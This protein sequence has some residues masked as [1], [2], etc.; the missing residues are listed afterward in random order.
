[1]LRAI[2]IIVALVISGVLLFAAT[3]PDTFRIQRTASIKAP[4]E[5]LF[6]LI[7][8]LRRFNTWNPYEKKD[9][10]MK[11]RYSGAARGKGAAY[12]FAGNRDVGMGSIEITDSAAPRQVSMRLHMI[13]PFEASNNIEFVLEPKGEVTQ[14]TWAME[15]NVPYPAKILQLFVSMDRMVGQDFEAGL[16]N[17][18]AAAEQ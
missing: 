3:R 13:E 14:V 12:A 18:K 8:D 10:D 6:P 1:M 16:A 4:P 15:G 9:P 5:K 2:T 11:G 17:L 7:N